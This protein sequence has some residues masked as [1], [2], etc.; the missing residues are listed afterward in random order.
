MQQTIVCRLAKIARISFV[1]RVII[2]GV[3]AI[4]VVSVRATSIAT[5][6][7]SRFRHRNAVGSDQCDII[8][9][10]QAHQVHLPLDRSANCRNT[11]DADATRK[12]PVPAEITP[13]PPANSKQLGVSR[14]LLYNGS[15]F[16]GSQKS[17]GNSYAVEVVLQ[18][19]P[20]FVLCV[21][22]ISYRNTFHGIIEQHTFALASVEG[23]FAPITFRAVHWTGTAT[24][25]ANTFGERRS[26]AATFYV[27]S[28][29]QSR[30]AT[31][32]CVC[33]R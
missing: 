26:S 9:S 16:E 18:V 25:T 32:L 20:A 21:W 5:N 4:V 31:M 33:E 22:H 27:A 15:R 28:Q 7:A 13:P 30:L 29:L 8:L 10:G 24:A 12:M 1:C 17:K 14:T 6:I 23:V 19:S 11:A 2:V 3:V